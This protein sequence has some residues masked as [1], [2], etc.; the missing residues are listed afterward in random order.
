MQK[1]DFRAVATK[2]EASRD[3]GAQLFCALLR[4]AGVE[5]RLVC[6][7]QVLPF[8]P[9][10]KVTMPV[11]PNPAITVKYP[12]TRTGIHD[13]GSAEAG[14]DTSTW[15]AGSSSLSVPTSR[16]ISR[17]GGSGRRQHVASG[18]GNPTVVPSV[19]RSYDNRWY[20]CL[21]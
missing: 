3:T 15:T 4:S 18:N 1:E 12:D 5:A 16:V 7:L 6:S 10:M 14:S 11:K 21:G 8:T 9:N 20:G 17:L 19:E 2:L 13:E